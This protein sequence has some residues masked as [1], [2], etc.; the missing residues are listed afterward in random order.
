MDA[1]A[2]IEAM[3]VENSNIQQRQK[4]K[5]RS[6]SAPNSHAESLVSL[7]VIETL[8]KSREMHL[9]C[10]V[11]QYVFILCIELCYPEGNQC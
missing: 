6:E 3:R 2:V 7:D 11:Q 8:H 9:Y 4:Q 10:I 5:P 1:R